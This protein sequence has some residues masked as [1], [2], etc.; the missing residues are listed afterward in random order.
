MTTAVCKACGEQ[1]FG[2]WLPCGKCGRV[3]NSFWLSDHYL[4]QSGL[5]FASGEIKRG[6]KVKLRQCWRHFTLAAWF[7]YLGPVLMVLLAL[8]S[9]VGNDRTPALASPPSTTQS[10][11][12][13]VH[14]R[15]LALAEAIIRWMA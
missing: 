15:D 14:L 2:A 8:A 12:A 5:D 11:A 6:R 9:Y 3:T 7:W 4:T 1:K 13:G 10:Q